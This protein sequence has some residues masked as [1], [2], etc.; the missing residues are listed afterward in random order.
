[1]LS[2]LEPNGTTFYLDPSGLNHQKNMDEVSRMD[3]LI[4][5]VWLREVQR[6]VSVA[7]TKKEG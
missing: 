3:L 4:L 1:M 7:L 2:W 5:Q 6:T